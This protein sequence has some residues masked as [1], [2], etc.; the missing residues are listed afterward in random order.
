MKQKEL[1]NL[2]KKIAKLEI[3]MNNSTDEDE[4]ELIANEMMVLTG[5]VHSFEEL[6]LLDEMIQEI[7]QNS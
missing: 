6:D 4:I 3:Q 5:R 1:K 2:A 7:L